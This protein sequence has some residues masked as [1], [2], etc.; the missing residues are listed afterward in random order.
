MANTFATNVQTSETSSTTVKY[1]TSNETKSK[2]SNK[3][4][5]DNATIQNSGPV[6]CM[7]C[8]ESHS[9]HKCQKLMATSME[10]K[11]KVVRDN[12]LGFT[13]LR[14]GHNSKVNVI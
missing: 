6:K 13:C 9:I 12:N 4:K 14:K 2:D 11:K 7:Y 8:E 3:P 5:K 10:E 1:N